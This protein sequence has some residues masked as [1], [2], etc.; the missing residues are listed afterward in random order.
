LTWS[1]LEVDASGPSSDSF[2]LTDGTTR[3]ERID[4]DGDGAVDLIKV[5]DDEAQPFQRSQSLWRSFIGPGIPAALLT[6]GFA[7][8]VATRNRNPEPEPTWSRRERVRVDA[9]KARARK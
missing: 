1:C 3:V 2:R 9:R 8:W 5:G 7:V 6:G 4:T